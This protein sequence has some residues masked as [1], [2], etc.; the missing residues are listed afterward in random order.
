MKKK[1]NLYS[2]LLLT[3]LSLIFFSGCDRGPKRIVDPLDII[4]LQH[5][6]KLEKDGTL[7]IEYIIKFPQIKEP[8]THEGMLKINEFYKKKFDDMTEKGTA[9]AKLLAEEDYQIAMEVDYEYRPHALGSNYE[10]KYNNNGIL[11]INLIEYTYWGGAH[12]NSFMESGLFDINT[13]QK[14]SLGR[15]FGLDEIQAKE[16]I[17]AEVRKQIQET[18]TE[19]IY[20]YDDFYE[21]L[22]ESFFEEDFY[23]D[24]ENLVVYFQQYA[25][26]PYAAGFPEFKIPA[27]EIPYFK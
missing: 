4:S 25:I 16:K 23:F 1:I 13:G 19:E 18:G 12:P 15:L 22:E 8:G 10:V 5:D 9:E 14:L 6:E 26:A 7:L 3:I 24:G 20:L 27:K 17:V 11:S 21:Y 2:V